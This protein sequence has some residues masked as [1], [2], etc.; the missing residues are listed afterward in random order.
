MLFQR[1]ELLHRQ[2]GIEQERQHVAGDRCRGHD[3]AAVLEDAPD[4][5]E[6]LVERCEP[7]EQTLIAKAERKCVIAEDAARSLAGGDHPDLRGA[8]FSRE[9]DSGHLHP[10]ASGGAIAVDYGVHAF[11]DER[12]MVG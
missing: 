2:G 4:G 3:V 7:L 1:G 5:V 8:G 10:G 9:E 6:R 12:Q 11:M